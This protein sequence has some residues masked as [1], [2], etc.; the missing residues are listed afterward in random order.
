MTVLGGQLESLPLHISGAKSGLWGWGSLQKD[1]DR[2]GARKTSEG[3]KK[4][5]RS[6]KGTCR[7]GPGVLGRWLQLDAVYW[8]NKME[9]I[10]TTY[11]QTKQMT[12]GAEGNHLRLA[13]RKGGCHLS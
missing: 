7:Q 2:E 13:T 4:Q 1:V 6:K 3:E 8:G 11:N 10:K 9:E 12:G 5:T